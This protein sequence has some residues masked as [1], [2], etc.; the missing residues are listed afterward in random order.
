MA[1]PRLEALTHDAIVHAEKDLAPAIR[2]M[3]RAGIPERV[4]MKLSGHKTRSVFDRYNGVSDGDLREASTGWARFWA[5]YDVDSR[6]RQAKP[7]KSLAT[8]R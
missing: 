2:N 6:F 4:A 7:A 5:Q 1:H 8:T 3:V